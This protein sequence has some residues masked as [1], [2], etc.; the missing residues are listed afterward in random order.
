LGDGR[1]FVSWVHYEDFVAAIRW[2][3]DRADTSG[4]VDI[5][6]PNPVPNSEFIP[7]WAEAGS[8]SLHPPVSRRS[9]MRG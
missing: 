5:A 8:R 7:C 2:L 1:Q 9:A 6:A 4:G 3:I